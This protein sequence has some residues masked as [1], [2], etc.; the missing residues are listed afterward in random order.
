M[1]DIPERDLQPPEAEI[2]SEPDPDQQRMDDPYYI[3]GRV[4]QV[5]MLSD[6]TQL[7]LNEFNTEHADIDIM[8]CLLEEWLIHDAECQKIMTEI[9]NDIQKLID[10]FR[11]SVPPEESGK[12]AEIIEKM[13]AGRIR[14]YLAEITLLGQPFI[15]DD[16][17]TVGKLLSDKGNATLRFVRYEVGEGIEK[18]EENF[19]EE[20]MAQVRGG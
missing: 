16:K 10:E 2:I 20:V 18:Q 11:I 3:E 4:K 6:R 15:K 12:P 7:A 9:S 8:K 19:A 1:N 13:I 17:V 5:G 14:K